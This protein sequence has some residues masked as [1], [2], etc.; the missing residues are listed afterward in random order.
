MTTL[1]VPSAPIRPS[2]RLVAWRQ[3]RNFGGW[4]REE[5]L[6][7]A[8]TACGK[9]IPRD[10]QGIGRVSFSLQTTIV[11]EDACRVC[12]PEIPAP[13]PGARPAWRP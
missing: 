11:P 4:H 7:D 1:P 9:E 8:R 3:R 12:W 5:H 6:G 13:A 10:L 2:G